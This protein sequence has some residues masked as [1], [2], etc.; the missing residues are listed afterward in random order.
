MVRYC[1]SKF[2]TYR[3]TE[4]CNF[5]YLFSIKTYFFSVFSVY[6][7]LFSIFSVSKFFIELEKRLGE[8]FTIFISYLEFYFRV[9]VEILFS[10]WF[11]GYSQ[12]HFYDILSR[13]QCFKF[14][15]VFLCYVKNRL[16]F[17]VLLTWAIIYTVYKDILRK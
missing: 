3:V 12:L 14:S 4:L 7:Y 5:Q 2:A 6:P 8:T 13:F 17:F 15:S 1:I 10:A 9:N 16:F 11:Y